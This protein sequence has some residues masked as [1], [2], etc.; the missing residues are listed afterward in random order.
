MKTQGPPHACFPFVMGLRIIQ[1]HIFSVSPQGTLSLR[2][3]DLL[4][5]DYLPFS[6]KASYAK[7][8][9]YTQEHPPYK[10]GHWRWDE[11]MSF[12]IENNSRKLVIDI[13]TRNVL[14]IEK[15]VSDFIP[16]RTRH[17]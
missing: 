9:R 12:P 3:S 2:P 7:Q 13:C 11:W 16:D 15:V 4:S 14:F 10:E 5:V 6:I 1:A 17:Y 8:K